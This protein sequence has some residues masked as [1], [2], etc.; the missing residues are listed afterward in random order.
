VSLDHPRRIFRS[1]FPRLEGRAVAV[2][3]GAGLVAAA[4]VSLAVLPGREAPHPGAGEQVSADPEQVIVIDGAT[5]R[6]AGRVVRLRGVDPPPH[7]M[8]CSSVDCGAAAT[9]SLAAIVREAR[10]SCRTMGTDDLGR[11]FAVCQARAKDL[12]VAIIE[13]GWARADGSEQELWRAETTAR[14]ERR[15]IWAYDPPW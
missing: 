6:L 5:L 11:A 8:S 1:N 15:G 12:N 2:A 7:S 4:G 3:I 10:V 9:N 14:A 13:S